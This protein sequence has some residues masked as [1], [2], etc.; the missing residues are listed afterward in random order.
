MVECYHHPC[1]DLAMMLT[2]DNINF[3]GKTSDAIARS[4]NELSE[5]IN[6][7]QFILLRKKEDYSSYSVI[8]I[9]KPS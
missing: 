2:D 7:G 6:P 4:I 8:S 3:L 5:P 1:D 9:K